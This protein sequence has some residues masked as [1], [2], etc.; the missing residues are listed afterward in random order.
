[1]ASTKFQT[2]TINL[3]GEKG[4]Y[5]LKATD[6][7]SFPTNIIEAGASIQGW[8]LRYMNESTSMQKNTVVSAANINNVSYIGSKL[9]FSVEM[10][11][12]ENIPSNYSI[13]GTIIVLIIAECE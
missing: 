8:E 6:E 1:M 5:E 7:V 13:Q 2:T 4:V 9:T 11:L 12:K 3:Q 10:V